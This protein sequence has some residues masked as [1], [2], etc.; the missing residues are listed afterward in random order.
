[1]GDWLAPSEKMRDAIAT[2][3][4]K[5]MNLPH[6]CLNR[7]ASPKEECKDAGGDIKDSAVNGKYF[8]AAGGFIFLNC[9]LYVFLWIN[10]IPFVALWDVACYHEQCSQCHLSSWRDFHGANCNML[11][12]LAKQEGDFSCERRGGP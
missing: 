6:R 2:E 8:T 4:Y 11:A 10:C 9:L 7:A 12:L 3:R 1:M 5:I